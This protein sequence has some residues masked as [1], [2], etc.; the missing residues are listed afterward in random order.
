MSTRQSTALAHEGDP[1]ASVEAA[2][3]LQAKPKQQVFDAIVA[4]L[5]E[6]ARA[7]FQV[8]QVYLERSADNG[9]PDLS[10]SPHSVNK[11]LS[12][13]H[14]AGR[15]R[16]VEVMGEQWRIPSPAGATATV[17]EVSPVEPFVSPIPTIRDILG[18]PVAS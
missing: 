8:Q 10:R 7:A 4:I 6:E 1:D 12:E 9:W 16:P 3:A 14:K 13:L 17:W 5:E 2:L 15:I 18:M 11:R